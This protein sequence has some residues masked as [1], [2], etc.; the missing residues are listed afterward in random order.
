MIHSLLL[1]L[2]LMGGVGTITKDEITISAS[3]STAGGK[4]NS[5]IW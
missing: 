1:L 4:I 2:L 5:L 3:S